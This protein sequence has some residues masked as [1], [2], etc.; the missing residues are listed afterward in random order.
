MSWL[1]RV[2]PPDGRPD[3]AHQPF[4]EEHYRHLRRRF[5]RYQSVAPR[6]RHDIARGAER[7]GGA[8]ARRRRPRFIR[9]FAFGR[10]GQGLHRGAR[11]GFHSFQDTPADGRRRGRP[12]EAGGTGHRYRAV[13]LR[14]TRPDCP[15]GFHQGLCEEHG[16][17]RAGTRGRG[18][19]QTPFGAVRPPDRRFSAQHAGSAPPRRAGRRVAGLVQGCDCRQQHGR[20]GEGDS[21]IPDEVRSSLFRTQGGAQPREIQRGGDYFQRPAR[22][23]LHPES[24][25]QGVVRV[26]RAALCR[27]R[28]RCQGTGA[29]LYE[30]CRSAGV[31]CGGGYSHLGYQ[32]CDERAVETSRDFSRQ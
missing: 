19:P 9:P 10:G 5:G 3:K 18:G 30:P 21:G 24:P 6:Y 8:A 2:P 25:I 1:R 4:H 31:Q 28:R 22:R 32:L 14:D 7:A 17:G 13:H 26:L 11:R 20:A 16:C 27:T 12:A 15:F 29:L 23:R